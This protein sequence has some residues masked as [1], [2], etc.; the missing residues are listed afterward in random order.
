METINETLE[1]YAATNP[2]VRFIVDNFDMLLQVH[3]RKTILVINERVVK[4]FNR[5]E[6]A[7]LY[8]DAIN[9]NGKK[10]AIKECVEPVERML[11]VPHEY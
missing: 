2:N 3:S 4:V 8:V 6:D 5:V 9:M 11:L 1:K 10:Y 7:M